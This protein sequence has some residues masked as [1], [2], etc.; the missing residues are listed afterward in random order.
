MRNVWLLSKNCLH[1]VHKKLDSVQN[2]IK[3]LQAGFK[4]ARAMPIGF[5]VQCLNHSAITAHD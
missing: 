2:K 1:S 5:R 4:P 3:T